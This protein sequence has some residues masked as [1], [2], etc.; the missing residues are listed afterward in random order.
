MRQYD[1]LYAALGDLNAAKQR[2]EELEATVQQMMVGC[3]PDADP[4]K[5]KRVYKKRKKNGKWSTYKKMKFA[6]KCK[7]RWAQMSKEERENRV[8]RMLMAR[9]INKKG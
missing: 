5:V 7:A 4:V 1:Q 8:Q 9:R 2:V 3:I 6:L